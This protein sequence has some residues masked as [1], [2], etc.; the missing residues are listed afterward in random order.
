MDLSMTFYLCLEDV[1][2]CVVWMCVVLELGWGLL[3]CLCCEDK[4]F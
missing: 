4:M 1:L 2:Q 3:S